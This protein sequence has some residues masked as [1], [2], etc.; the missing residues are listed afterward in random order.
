ML[1][2]NAWSFNFSVDRQRLFFVQCAYGPDRARAP[3]SLKAQPVSGGASH[4]IFQDQTNVLEAIR[5]FSP[6]WLLFIISSGNGDTSRDGLWRIDADGTG[7]SHLSTTTNSYFNLSSQ[8]PWS[9]VSR[10]GSMYSLYDIGEQDKLYIGSFRSKK[11]TLIATLAQDLWS[12]EGI[13]GWTVC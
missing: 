10:D 2:A 11:I 5:V 4:I 13:V 12:E 1:P 6:A 9:D 8:S 3:C 7:L